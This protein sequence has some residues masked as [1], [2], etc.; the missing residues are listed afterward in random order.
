[1]STHFIKT[2]LSYK[3]LFPAFLLLSLVFYSGP[4]FAQYESRKAYAGLSIGP[5]IPIGDFASK[6][7]ALES[8]GY[9]N[10]GF[11]F[12]INF[13]Y[14]IASNFGFTAM[15]MIQSSTFD[16]KELL[17]GLNTIGNV[18]GAPAKFTSVEANSW[19]L[20]S[21]MPGIFASIP[22]GSNGKVVLEPRA[23][24]GLMT[25]ISPY[26]KITW[27]ENNRTYWQEQENGAGFGFGYSVGGGIRFNMSDHFALLMNADYIKTKPK[28]FD[29]VINFSDNTSLLS[30]FQQ[31]ME[32]VN[33]SV[34]FA[35]RFKKDVPP[36]RKSIDY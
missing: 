31:T 22:L 30:S 29:V 34:G 8:A 28:F 15:V 12:N 18:N 33:M 11:D 21:F 7:F 3:V 16:D 25:A 32:M 1:M 14:R 10:T 4:S 2:F 17:N 9:A 13:A 6:N 24:V 5:S 19:S 27:R 26:V 36:I 23:L 20:V 35:I